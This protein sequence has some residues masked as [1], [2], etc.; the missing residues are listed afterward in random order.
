MTS[1]SRS[2]SGE[3]ECDQTALKVLSERLRSLYEHGGVMDTKKLWF[4]AKGCIFQRLPYYLIADDVNVATV[5]C[6]IWMNSKL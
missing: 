3:L 6:E 5:L 1:H 4:G 2:G